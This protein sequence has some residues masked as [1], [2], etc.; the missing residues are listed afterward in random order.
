MQ[1]FAPGWWRKLEAS[2]KEVFRVARFHFSQCSFV[3][4]RAVDVKY[5]QSTCTC[6]F[7]SGFLDG[8]SLNAVAIHAL[9]DV[10]KHHLLSMSST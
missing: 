4:S 2:W 6:K 7:I 1:D 5:I 10:N 9:E 8:I 3:Y